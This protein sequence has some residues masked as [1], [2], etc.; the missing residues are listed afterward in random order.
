MQYWFE[1]VELSDG[2]TA[3]TLIREDGRYIVFENIE[4]L[5]DIA[6]RSEELLDAIFDLVDKFL[7]T[8]YGYGISS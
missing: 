2:S 4:K 3:L 1:E 8:T 6:D 5:F 7:E